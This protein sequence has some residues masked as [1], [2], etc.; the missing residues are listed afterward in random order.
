MS[1]EI[2]TVSLVAV[3]SIVWSGVATGAH[4]QQ[5]PELIGSWTGGPVTAVAAS[6]DVAY[7][8][9]GTNLRVIDVSIPS[10]PTEVGSCECGGEDD[11]VAA[12]SHV[13]LIKDGALRVVDVSVPA[14][15]VEEGACVAGGDY[16]SAVTGGFVFAGGVWFLASIDVQ[17]PWNPV[18]A[19]HTIAPAEGVAVAGDHAYLASGLDGLS[20]W[21]VG[22]P[23]SLVEVGSLETSGTVGDVAVSDRFAYLARGECDTGCPTGLLVVDVTEPSTPVEVSFVETP[24]CPERLEVSGNLLLL[25]DRSGVAV[26]DLTRPS[27]PVQVGYHTASEATSRFAVSGRSVYLAQGESGFEILDISGCPGFVPGP[28]PPRLADGRSTP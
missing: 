23:F 14:S 27:A 15:P 6:A 12:R 22:D 3:L 17:I 4:G 5:C 13:Y 24:C 16:V 7:V 11:F 9:D 20:V 28:P 18:P 19:D 2:G 25:T 21:N 1:T 26:Y 10:S 8:V